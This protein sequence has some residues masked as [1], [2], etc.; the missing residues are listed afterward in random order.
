[1]KVSKSKGLKRYHKDV[2]FPDWASTS[3]KGFAK[4]VQIH[5]SIAFSLHALEKVVD[6]G[7]EYGKKFVKFLVKTIRQGILKT[8]NVFEFYAEDTGI[9]KACFR[10][11]SSEVPVDLVLVISADG[12]VVTAFV[13]N[14]GDNHT[15]LDEK[16][17]ERKP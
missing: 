10:I 14:K 11:S 6:Y 8:D 5:G 3:L 1:M 4:G 15:T 12:V 13:I 2:Y 16:M 17:Y 7:T 9:K